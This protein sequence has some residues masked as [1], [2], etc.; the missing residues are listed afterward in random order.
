[1]HRIFNL[2]RVQVDSPRLQGD[3]LCLADDMHRIR[4]AVETLDRG[5]IR[6]RVHHIVYAESIEG[7]TLGH[8]GL[9]GQPGI[10]FIGGHYR[11]AH[12][13]SGLVYLHLQKKILTDLI[14]YFFSRLEHDV[15]IHI[16][17]APHCKRIGRPVHRRKR[18]GSP[19][20]TATGA[21]T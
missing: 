4:L 8:L 17:R 12:I 10:K 13:T 18:I 11:L 19:A 7:R 21:A 5:R 6:V 16:H 15:L 3:Q 2:H 9:R 1:M 14:L 20:R